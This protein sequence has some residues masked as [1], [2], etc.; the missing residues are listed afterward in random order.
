M[1]S[2]SQKDCVRRMAGRHR[3]E[4]L[5]RIN[6]GERRRRGAI[7]YP[8][9]CLFNRL[10]VLGLSYPECINLLLFFSLRPFLLSF[11]VIQLLVY[12]REWIGN[13]L[14][15]YGFCYSAIVFSS[16]LSLV[17]G[18]QG[19]SSQLLQHPPRLLLATSAPALYTLTPERQAKTNLLLQLIAFV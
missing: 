12:A 15:N 5:D 4:Y 14:K 8:R 7:E 18:V 19:V 10:P 16:L 3:D 17:L 9:H 13:P 11:L 1:A 6:M 2:C